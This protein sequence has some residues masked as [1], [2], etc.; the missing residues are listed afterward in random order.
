MSAEGG[1]R[2]GEEAGT[3]RTESCVAVRGVVSDG[4]ADLGG[5]GRAPCDAGELPET[6]AGEWTAAIAAGRSPGEEAWAGVG[7]QLE[8][9]EGGGAM[10][11]GGGGD[12]AGI[13]ELT[14]C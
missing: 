7:A 10:G 2:K 6:G 13:H 1:Q 14:G 11:H 4:L 3:E 12:E 9:L 5:G 8:E